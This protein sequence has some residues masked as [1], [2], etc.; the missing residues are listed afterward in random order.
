MTE[1]VALVGLALALSAIYLSSLKRPN[2][3]I[4]VPEGTFFPLATLE[5]KDGRWTA[6]RLVV[7]V[8][9]TNSGAKAGAL[10]ELEPHPES[11]VRGQSVVRYSCAVRGEDDK[12]YALPAIVP[13]AGVILRTLNFYGHLGHP[14]PPEEASDERSPEPDA[15]DLTV[16]FRYTATGGMRLLPWKRGQPIIRRRSLRVTRDLLPLDV[17]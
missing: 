2:V 14:S 9:I 16:T 5:R 6:V 1:A 10:L 12:E 7:P 17:E 13:A 15:L 8:C 4:V 3:R 11:T